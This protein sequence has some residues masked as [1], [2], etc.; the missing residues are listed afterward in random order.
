M[1]AFCVAPSDTETHGLIFE[2]DLEYE[3]HC[4]LWDT[5]S[6]YLKRNI[7]VYFKKT[8]KQTKPKNIFPAVNPQHESP[9]WPVFGIYCVGVIGFKNC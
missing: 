8:S 6:F 2:T 9:N 4:F 3:W 1:C 7:I 5:L